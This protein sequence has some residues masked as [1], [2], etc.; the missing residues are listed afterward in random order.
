M[1]SNIFA[2][3]STSV[4]VILIDKSGVN[5][6]VFIDASKLGD[7]TKDGKNKKSKS[8]ITPVFIKM[9]A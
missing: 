3:T 1:P 5:N 8:P 9:S 6:P 2:N 7:E 4:S